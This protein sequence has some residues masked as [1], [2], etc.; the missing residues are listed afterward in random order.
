[1]GVFS[2]SVAFAREWRERR[3]RRRMRS[4]ERVR[5]RNEAKAKLAPVLAP[6]HR[7]EAT[8][9]E[10]VIRDADRDDLYPRIDDKFRVWRLS[11]WF[12]AELGKEWGDGISVWEENVRGVVG[13]GV[14]RIVDSN[15]HGEGIR[16]MGRIPYEVVVGVDLEGDSDYPMPQIFCHFDYNHARSPVRETV[17]YRYQGFKR[18]IALEGVRI[19]GRQRSSLWRR[20][21]FHRKQKKY[22]REFRKEH[23]EHP[24]TPPPVDESGD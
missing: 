24:P 4:D 6:L 7:M 3:E 14:V 15:E 11:P 20:W 1:V 13:E 17:A 16:I 12:K 9:I 19:V 8:S 5:T 22:E 23:P 18:W 10:V 2:G 21:R